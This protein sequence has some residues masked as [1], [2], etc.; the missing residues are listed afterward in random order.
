V[1]FKFA[2]ALLKRVGFPQNES[3]AFLRSVLDLVALGTISDYAPLLG[4]NRV[5]VAHGLQQI[6]RTTN[7]GVAE[8][9]KL[10]NINT[11]KLATH[12]I[13]FQIAPRINAAGRTSHAGVCVELLTTNDRARAA[14]IAAQLDGFNTDRRNVESQIFQQCLQYV[15]RHL[16][17]ERDRVFVVN[18]ADW[19][20]GV[21]GI[22]ASRIMDMYDRP[23][24]VL[25]EQQGAAKGS[26]RSLKGFNIHAALCACQQ[27]LNGFGGHPNAAGLS[28]D[29][30]KIASF[31][32]AINA[33]AV[34]AGGDEDPCPVLT[35]DT[36]VHAWELDDALMRDLPLLE[37]HGHSNPAPLL[38]ARNLRIAD[39]PR[40]V[41]TNHLK[42][43][44]KQEGRLIGAIGFG[45]GS[46]IQ[47]LQTSRSSAVEV[48]FAPTVN[49]YFA[50]P[51]VEMELKDL[52]F[53]A[54]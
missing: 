16:D 52:R 2:H 15:E 9:V 38:Y 45:M 21:V 8:L 20:L 5:L 35:V 22:V 36:E 28:L 4:E 43:Q 6:R 1:A 10:L 26:A 14:E 19:H 48:V 42:L 49:T 39:A 44:F 33:Y 25:S 40:I 17:V 27:Y 3:T 54:R 11:D 29:V 37:P 23:V 30:D 32:E 13:G 53:T 31:R 47:E 12:H 50:Q 7:A 18:G 34:Q 51:R 41:G 46:R 24:I